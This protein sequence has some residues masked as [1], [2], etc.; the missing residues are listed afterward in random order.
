MASLLR[1][2][3]W[4]GLV[5]VPL[6]LTGCN[7]LSLPFFIFGPE[8]AR[9]PELKQLAGEDK[10]K[11]T[12]VLILTYSKLSAKPEFVR[13][14]RDL[15]ERLRA[16][17]KAGFEY[18]K[19]NV[20]I[21]VPRRIEEFKNENPGWQTMDLDQVG[22]QFGADYV[23]YLEIRDLS[24]YEQKSSNTLYRGRAEIN[25]SLID[26]N[27]PDEGPLRK[28]FVCQYPSETRHAIPVE[29]ISLEK[30]RNDFLNYAAKRLSWYFTR[31]PTSAEHDCE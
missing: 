5:L 18:N 11:D 26:V 17:L 30:F 2:T 25:V 16:Q 14:D 9:E 4:L 7:L 8:P 10:K 19:E 31:H 28:D 21:A 27:H 23:V 13:V 1:R 20:R 29:D 22:K 24:L 12:K 3:F 6:A 15:S